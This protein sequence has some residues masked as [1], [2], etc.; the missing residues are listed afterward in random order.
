VIFV[1]KHHQPYCNHQL[2]TGGFNSDNP[3]FIEFSTELL[4]HGEW[5]NI[6]L[7]PNE[8]N[9]ILP[10]GLYSHC[11]VQINTDETAIIG[12]IFNLNNN[13]NNDV[14]MIAWNL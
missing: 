4:Q 13:V 12:G 1:N 3:D 11:S 5:N 7:K 6:E 10:K 8:T 14:R 9:L 2:A